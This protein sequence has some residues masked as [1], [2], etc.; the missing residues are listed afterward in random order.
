[1][2]DRS[3]SHS[4]ASS[5]LIDSFVIFVAVGLL[6]LPLF[7]ISYTT[8][9]ASIESTFIADARFLL[10]HWPHPNWQPLWYGG[11][12]WDYIYPPALR[13][14]TAITS[15]LL[16]TETVVGYHAYTTTLYCLGI[17]GVYVLARVGGRSRRYAVVSAALAALVSPAYLF[18]PQIRHDA[19]W[20]EPQRLRVLVQWGEGPHMSAFALLGFALAASYRALEFRRTATLALAALLCAAVVAH[21]F[22]G[23]TALAMFFPL[24]VWSLWVTHRSW[25]LLIRAGLIVILA[26]GLTAYWLVPSYLRVTADNLKL[27][28]SPG[29]TWSKVIGLFVLVAFG[30]ASLKFAGRRPLRAWS[31][32]LI[33]S[34]V[35]FSLVVLGHAW[36]GFRIVGEPVRL[37]PE[38]D[39]VMIL[40][41]VLAIQ[42]AFSMNL[43]R[44][45][46]T[47]IAVAITVFVLAG[48][49]AYLRH[50]WHTTNT[51][52]AY[53][54]RVEYR[55]QEW[56]SQNS[57]G[58]RNFVM[59]AVRFWYNTWEDLPQFGG[60]SEQGVLNQAIMPAMWE[61]RLGPDPRP[62]V[63]WLQCFGTALVTVSDVR[64][65]DPYHDYPFAGKFDGV[66]PLRYDDSRGNRIYRVPRR[67]PELARVVR[68]SAIDAALPPR[69]NNDVERL[70]IYAAA[71]EKG[72]DTQPH[73]EWMGTDNARVHARY[74]PG[75]WLLMQMA[76]DPNWI[77]ETESKR[78]RTRRDALGQMIVETFP[79]EYEIRLSFPT[80]LENRVGFGVT[81]A[82]A[83]ICLALSGR[84]GFRRRSTSV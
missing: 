43:G 52:L 65:E 48:S 72:P 6:V 19:P 67:F 71:L 45:M 14:G 37:I 15:R 84:D 39:L 83:V 42:H 29:N 25:P 76:Y 9:W 1:M 54:D 62:S 75:E 64:S 53:R 5:Y 28:A 11:T 61:V 2:E 55:I 21:N 17:V 12:R 3:A 22:Y 35:V 24:L 18:L 33:G 68:A 20:H 74:S 10:D 38:L 56:V 69:G 58:E 26:Y 57:P 13:Y 82:A 27:V 50:A 7:T 16:G 44:G 59:G 51:D 4:G 70:Q 31:V 40:I 34:L 49:A 32:F 23:A 78:L 66:L 81:A 60:G 47:T 46:K 41:G 30:A 79:G 73:L 8:N 36:F 63:L 80:P 77:A